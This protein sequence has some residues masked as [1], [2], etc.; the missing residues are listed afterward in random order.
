MTIAE[1]DSRQVSGQVNA[2]YNNDS[3]NIRP[4]EQMELK[5]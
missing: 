2:V 5:L 3:S 4:L 1:L